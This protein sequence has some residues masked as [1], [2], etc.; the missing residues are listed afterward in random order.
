MKILNEGEYTG[1]IVQ[2]MNIDNLV[3]T[4]TRYSE[5]ISNPEWHYHENLHICFVFQGGKAETRQA[6]KYTAQGGSIFFYH[7]EEKHRWISPQPVSKSANI[8]ICDDF[9]KKYNFSEFRIKE[10]I[11]KKVDVKTIILKIQKEM[12]ADDINSYLSIQSLL[13][14][15]LSPTAT[16]SIKNIP[17]WVICLKELLHDN[18][19]QNL[20]LAELANITQ[21][22]PVTIS[23][24]FR[25]YFS[26]TLGEYRRKIKIEKSID[27]IK[28][29]KKSLSE[30][31]FLCNFSDQSHF[32]RNFK[33][34]TGFLPKSF[35]SF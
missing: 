8:E 22:H 6:T 21:V 34:C 32:T 30:I 33:E 29:S 24:F 18:W 7:A 13:L 3:I 2:K 10:A 23:K 35:R 17:K 26:C 5:K 20:S 9:I 27:L 4:N 12:V 16:D 14:E 11:E 15:L 19:N 28:N 1:E 31:A 25:K